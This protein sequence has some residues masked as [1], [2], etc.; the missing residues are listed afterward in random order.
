MGIEMLETVADVREKSSYSLKTL[1]LQVGIHTGKILGGLIGQNY[2]RYDIF[3]P[4]VLTA[5]KVMEESPSGMI[6]VSETTHNMIK[7]NQ[8][9]YDTFDFQQDK[10][11]TI[12]HKAIP[13]YTCEQIFVGIESD[14]D[15]SDDPERDS[16]SDSEQSENESSLESS[17]RRLKRGSTDDL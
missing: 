13:T 4:D 9:I 10:D 17:V 3:G 7:H 5:F 16:D 1:D 11:I 6:R 2:V 15:F 8:F 14:S 12:Y